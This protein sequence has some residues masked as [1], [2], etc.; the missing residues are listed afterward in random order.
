MT[1]RGLCFCAAVCI[2][3]AGGCSSAKAAKPVCAADAGAS[4]CLTPQPRHVYGLVATGFQPNSELQL[5]RPEV[6]PPTAVP[7]HFHI[8]GDGA[9]SIRGGKLTLIGPA[10]MRVVLSGTAG[11]GTAVKLL[12]VLPG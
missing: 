7:L 1:A 2:L 9:F 8:G 4:V 12:V 11:S 5:S 3:A 10:P 6:D